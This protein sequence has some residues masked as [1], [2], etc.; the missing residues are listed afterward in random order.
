MRRLVLFGA[1]CRLVVPTLAMTNITAPCDS[2]P[3]NLIVN[4]GFETGDF[5]GWTQSGNT[6]FTSVTGS[7][8]RIAPNSGNFPAC[9]G[10]VGS[11]GLLSQTFGTQAGATYQISFYEANL[12]G[13]PRDSAPSSTETRSNRRT[14]RRHSLIRFTLTPEQPARVRR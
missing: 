11:D 7:F 9:M 14:R 3:G 6:G 2:V 5:T 1:V 12:G 10:P 13:S 8:G 4:C